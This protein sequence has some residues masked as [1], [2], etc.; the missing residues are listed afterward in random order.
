MRHTKR[1]TAQDLAPKVAESGR[2]DLCTALFD[3]GYRQKWEHILRRRWVWDKLELLG[4]DLC[5]G[6]TQ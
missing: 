6:D 3:L 4:T 5:V 1:E 2:I